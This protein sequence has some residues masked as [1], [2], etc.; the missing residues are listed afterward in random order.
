MSANRIT[1]G[2]TLS[3]STSPD[4]AV[5]QA[6]R[7]EQLG[8]D[9]V[10]LGEHFARP[11]VMASEY[12]YAATR[13]PLSS[14]ED[15]SD[16]IAVAAAIAAST[17]RL[18]I[19]TGIYLFPLRH[20]LVTARSAATLQV[21]SKNRFL[22]GVAAGWAKEEYDA[23]DIPFKQRGSRLDEGIEVFRK[24]LA[25]GDFEHHGKHYNF[26]TLSVV[27][28]ARTTPIII[29]GAS[30]PA[31][32]RAAHLGDG[33]LSPPGMTVEECAAFRTQIDSMRRE[34]GV[35]SRPF[36][37]YV[38]AP[39]AQADEARRFADAGMAN[40]IV[41][42]RQVSESSDPLEKKLASLEKAAERLGVIAP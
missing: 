23:L 26:D 20:P 35:E 2:L 38:R 32:R 10:W 22:L 34:H 6:I 14:R 18:L 17:S 41:G 8:F 11:A 28:S 21:I 27:N 25:G 39:E 1:Y 13:R 37:I 3:F 16:P 31:L 15:C 40:V 29:G 24:A 33:W 7:A 36:T 42:G 4:E 19:G 12:P 5:A 30:E 9:S